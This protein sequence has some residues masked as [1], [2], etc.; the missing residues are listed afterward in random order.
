[1]EMSNE[2]LFRAPLITCKFNGS[3]E[4]DAKLQW[5]L[6]DLIRAGGNGR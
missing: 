6:M 2:G 3:F 1:M 4:T 5:R